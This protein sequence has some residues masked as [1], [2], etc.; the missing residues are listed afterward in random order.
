[1]DFT[2]VTLRPDDVRPP[3]L[4]ILTFGRWII[5]LGCCDMLGTDDGLTFLVANRHSVVGRLTVRT[6]KFYNGVP[7]RLSINIFS[8]D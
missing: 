2:C 7:V 1:M 5:F 6:I 8:S 4:S 3:R